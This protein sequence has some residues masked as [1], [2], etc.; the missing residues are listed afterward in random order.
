MDKELIVKYLNNQC[1]PAELEEVIRWVKSKQWSEDA[2]DEVIKCWK[3]ACDDV[4]ID[5]Q[6]IDS[7]FDN[8]LNEIESDNTRYL[9]SHNEKWNYSNTIKLISRV[10]VIL[11][12]PVL[13][14][15]SYTISERN[16]T[17]QNDF[18]NL[19]DSLEVIAPL[20][21]RTVV[22]LS[23]RTVIH[24]NSGSKI[25]YPQIFKG[26]SREV[27]LIGEAFFEV[28]HKEDMPFIVK[29]EFLNIAVL[30]T[31]FNVSAYSNQNIIETTLVKGKV[32]IENAKTNE[33]LGGMIPGQHTNFNIS[34]GTI[35]SSTG[36]VDKFI[37]WIDGVI[38]FEETPITE[39]ADKLSRMFN[40]EII[41]KE[42]IMDYNYTV[43]LIDEPL[44][45]IMDL[46]TL[47]S[48]IKYSILKREKNPDGTYS[49]QRIILDKK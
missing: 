1:S 12:I 5:D 48:P 14:L 49:K 10:A 34:D 22:Q 46:M 29:T 21:S 16:K 6:R 4:E 43:T 18:Q 11:L 19:T 13:L 40:V 39:V 30:G 35:K 23:D 36:E 33:E 9:Q 38:I 15:F 47:A 41:V 27:T 37:A 31:S 24:L 32:R 42:S 17:A 45:Q 8:I 28:T 25:K 44:Y 3:S 26:D 2:K 20:G 7:I